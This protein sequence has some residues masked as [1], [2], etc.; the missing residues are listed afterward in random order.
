MPQFQIMS[1]ILEGRVNKILQIFQL[2]NSTNMWILTGH[3]YKILR[4]NSKVPVIINNQH[5]KYKTVQNRIHWT[6]V[7]QLSSNRDFNLLYFKPL[8]H[9]ASEH[10]EHSS[11]INL[12]ISKLKKSLAEHEQRIL[13][14]I[15]TK[16]KVILNAPCQTAAVLNLVKDV[17]T[18]RIERLC[19][20]RFRESLLEPLFEARAS[21][22]RSYCRGVHFQLATLKPPW[23]IFITYHH[24]FV[25]ILWTFFIL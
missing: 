24:C 8:S 2:Q 5:G 18:D 10:S 21:I 11:P 12:D 6:N 22:D 20:S 14:N 1:V 3:E 15:V 7:S 13:I 25:T 19:N 23:E 9:I 17:V 4:Y 16:D